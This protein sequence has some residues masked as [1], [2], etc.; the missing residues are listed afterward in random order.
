MTALLYVHPSGHLNDLVVPAGALS[1]M[2]AAPGPKLGRYSFEVKDE[3]ISAAR[4]IAMDVHWALSL[5]GF[6]RLVAHVRSLRPDVPIVVGGVTAGHYARDLLTRYPVDY[7]LQGDSERSFAELVEHLLRGEE[8]PVLPNVH[9]RER[10]PPPLQRMARA[11]FDESDPVTADWF[12]TYERHA[13]WDAAAFP[14]GRTIPVSRGCAFRCPE[15]YGSYASTYGRGY[16]LRSPERLGRLMKRCERLNVRNLR[17]FIAKPP[18]RTLTDLLHGLAAEGPYRFGSTVGLYLCTAPS[19]EDLDLLEASFETPVALSMIPPHEHV[20]ALR[21]RRL[22]FEEKRWR[23]AAERIA[24]SRVLTLDAWS[25]TTNDLVSLKRKLSDRD[26]ARVKVSYGAVWSVTRPVD[27]VANSFDTVRDAMVPV[28]TFYAGRVLSPSIARM[29]APFRYLDEL[30]SDVDGLTCP[31]E[32][33]RGF[34]EASRRGWA[35]HHL[36]YLP[37]LRFS[38]V[39]LRDAPSVRKRHGVEL[40]GALGVVEQARIAGDPLPLV[41]LAD[42]KGIGLR[43]AFTID[44]AVRALAIVP[45]RMPDGGLDGRYVQALAAD[46]LV[47][48]AVPPA[49]RRATLELLVRVQGVQAALLDDESSALATGRGDLRYFRVPS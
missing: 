45:H 9:A 3:E 30:D 1:C 47:A 41:E 22:A 23:A 35:A 26:H 25:T 28:W 6:E 13:N 11:E 32:S 46:G 14:Q 5:P 19:V 16:H 33:V 20:P 8:P 17:L 15:C 37:G 7:V 36:P 34:F 4:V 29:L 24:R 18:D 43:G 40:H 21:P 39:P 2:N 49:V 31:S 38:L 48:F 10:P 27:G 44:E 12:P 42:H